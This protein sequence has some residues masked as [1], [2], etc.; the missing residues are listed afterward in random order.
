MNSRHTQKRSRKPTHG[1][2]Q[3]K[4]QHV[5]CIIFPKLFFHLRSECCELSGLKLCQLM[6][7]LCSAETLSMNAS[8]LVLLQA[9]RI[10]TLV[11]YWHS[12]VSR[13]VV[14]SDKVRPASTKPCSRMMTNVAIFFD[15]VEA[16]DVASTFRICRLGSASWHAVWCGCS[17]SP[18][19]P[20]V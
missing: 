20:K 19:T 3:Q 10:E 7:F 14:V 2:S 12:F 16:V 15:M 11:I 17:T 9:V 5:T 4:S 13:S 18:R 6:R 1:K 8:S